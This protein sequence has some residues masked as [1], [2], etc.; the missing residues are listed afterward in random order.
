MKKINITNFIKSTQFALSKHSPEILTG[1]GIAGMITTTILA[2]K[3]TPKA[4][5]EIEEFEECILCDHEKIKPT[6]AVKITWKYYIP[7][8]VTGTVSIACLIGASSVNVRR[9]AALATAYKLSE[10]ALTEYRD[11]VVETIGEKKEQAVR[12]AV[13]KD[14]IEKNPVNQQNVIITGKGDT[15]C[16]DHLFG[17]YFK[18]DIDKLKRITNELNRRMRDEMYISLNEFYYEVGLD[19]VDAGDDIGWDIDRGYIDIDFSSHLASDGTPCL[20]VSFS[21]PPKYNFK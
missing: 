21:I 3:A 19:G 13:A 18:S 17:R 2:V 9:N 8:A 14:K 4:V 12:E 15:L 6:D 7:A 20:D 11:K 16:Y 1:L 5:K 10:T